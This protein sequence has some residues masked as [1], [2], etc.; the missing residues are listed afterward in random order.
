MINVFGKVFMNEDY[1]LLFMMVKEVLDKEIYDYVLLDFYVEI[2]FEKIVIVYFLE[3]KVD[4][5]VGI[6]MYI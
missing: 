2:I 6:Y 3:G 5:M 1:E 4:M